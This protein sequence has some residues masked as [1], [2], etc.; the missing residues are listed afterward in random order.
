MFHSVIFN[1]GAQ[2]VKSVPFEDGRPVVVASATYK[3]VDLRKSDEDSDRDVVAST[4]ASVDSYSGTTQAIAGAGAADPTRIDLDDVTGLAVGSRYLLTA[5]GDQQL[6]ELRSVDS[7]NNYAYTTAPITDQFASGATLSGIE[8]SGTFP[9]AEAAD[10]LRLEAGGGP[11]AVDWSFN[12]VPGPVRELIWLRR[13]A[14]T[15]MITVDDVDTLDAQLVRV[16]GNLFSIDKLI[17]QGERDF[18]AELLAAGIH[19]ERFHGTEL[20]RNAVTYR[21]CYLGRLQMGR[22][23]DDARLEHYHGRWMGLINQLTIGRPGAGVSRTSVD[24]SAEEG[25]TGMVTDLIGLS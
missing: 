7:G 25:D 16:T 13:H 1:Q 5:A 23:A 17:E 15:P 24:D 8:V 11:Y 9:S 21:V 2:T 3:I 20:A 19:P 12:G 22:D 18:N 14:R 10:E 4:A 6:V